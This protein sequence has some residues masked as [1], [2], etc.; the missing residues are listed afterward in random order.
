[1]SISRNQAVDSLTMTKCT[2]DPGAS[3]LALHSFEWRRVRDHQAD[4]GLGGP[5]W[6]ADGDS[7]ASERR[8]GSIFGKGTRSIRPGLAWLR[9]FWALTDCPRDMIMCM[10]H[11]TGIL[12]RSIEEMPLNGAFGR[13]QK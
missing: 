13:R 11:P 7:T 2:H 9:V 10:D 8:W 12:A 6:S 3:G 4:S 1:M 5:I